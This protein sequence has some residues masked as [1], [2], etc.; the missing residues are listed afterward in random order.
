MKMS[1]NAL[2][3]ISF[4]KLKRNIERELQNSRYQAIAN[5]IDFDSNI[6]IHSLQT[7]P[8]EATNLAMIAQ[9]TKVPK[10]FT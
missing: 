6:N 9:L 2:R 1:D 10:E 5:L 3:P 7:E 4:A 8:S